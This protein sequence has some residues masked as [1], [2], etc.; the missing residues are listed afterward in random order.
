MELNEKST[1]ELQSLEQPQTDW[2]GIVVA[3]IVGGWIWATAV[4]PSLIIYAVEQ[5]ASVLGYDWPQ[6]AYPP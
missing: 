4:L 3:M 6:W 5:V 2:L 1:S